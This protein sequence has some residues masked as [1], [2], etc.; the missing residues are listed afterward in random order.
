MDAKEL[1]G[2]NLRRLRIEKGLSQESLGLAVGCEPSYIG[3]VERGT[4]NPTVMTLEAFAAV[5]DAHISAFF[6]VA[7]GPMK[8][9]PTLAPGRKPQVK[10]PKPKSAKPR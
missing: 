9:L 5:L 7:K 2:W 1:V 6:F 4:E 3:R 10:K 8:P